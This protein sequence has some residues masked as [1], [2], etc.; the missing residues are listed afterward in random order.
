MADSLPVPST[1]L[2][3]GYDDTL[4][5][6]RPEV[7]RNRDVMF[8]GRLNRDKGVHV[9]LEALR[10]LKE[11]GRIA[12]LTIVGAGGEEQ[13]IRRQVNET[14]LSEQVLFAGK[15]EGR[16]VGMLLN[17]HRVLAVPSLVAETFGLVV[18]EGLASGCGVIA[19]DVGAL[20]ETVGPCGFMFPRGDAAAL[21]ERIETMLAQPE[22][23]SEHQALAADHLQPFRRTDS[24]QSYLTI[25]E[26]AAQQGKRAVPSDVLFSR[27]AL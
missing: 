14:G 5:H 20:K 16:E 9:V 2:G 3:N 7:T 8:L 13:E 22:I 27:D 12:T 6:L 11:K 15:K 24:L 10:L 1:V 21:A 4:F 26:Q 17:Q 18:M 23:I 25:I 19:S